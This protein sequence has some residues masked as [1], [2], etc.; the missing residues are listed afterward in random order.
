MGLCQS[1][2]EGIYYEND[3]TYILKGNNKHKP[4]TQIDTFFLQPG[5]AILNKSGIV[6][7]P[8]TFRKWGGQIQNHGDEMVLNL[9]K[10]SSAIKLYVPP[11]GV[12]LGII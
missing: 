11:K 10:K 2:I 1:E 8:L 5:S 7:E 4:S 9:P 3:L 12:W 6:W